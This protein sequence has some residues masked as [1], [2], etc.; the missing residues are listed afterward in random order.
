MHIHTNE[1]QIVD[2]DSAKI[3]GFNSRCESLPATHQD[4]CKFS[5]ADDVGYE[6]VAGTICELIDDAQLGRD[7]YVANGR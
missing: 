1:D 2:Q 5:S 7:Q 6:R 3:G 4:M